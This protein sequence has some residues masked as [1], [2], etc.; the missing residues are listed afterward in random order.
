MVFAVS[1][2]ILG[3]FRAHLDEQEQMDRRLDHVGDLLARVHGDFLYRLPALAEHDLSLALALDEHG[4]LDA[5]QG[6]LEG[7][8]TDHLDPLEHAVLVRPGL[9]LLDHLGPGKRVLV[10]DAAR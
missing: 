1:L 4:L 7:L 5:D 3:P 6:I 8:G 2:R 10:S 9:A